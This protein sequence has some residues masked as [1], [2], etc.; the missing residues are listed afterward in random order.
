MSLKANPKFLAQL[1]E[2]ESQRIP[3]V[4]ILGESELERGVVKLRNVADR[5]EV[6]IPRQ[7]V[8]VELRSRLNNELL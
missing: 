7:D 4:L 2:C 5:K 8:I 1:Q 6:E 3:W